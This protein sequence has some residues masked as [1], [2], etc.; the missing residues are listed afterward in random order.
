LDHDLDLPVNEMQN[1][2]IATI[3]T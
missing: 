3:H 2:I 1:N